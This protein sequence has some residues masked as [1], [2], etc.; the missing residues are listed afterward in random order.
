[1]DSVK[2]KA[3]AEK[4]IWLAPV[5]PPKDEEATVFGKEKQHQPTTKD[6]AFPN[7]ALGRGCPSCLQ[8]TVETLCQAY[9]SIQE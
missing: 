7:Q 9:P 4:R 6:P 5:F 3:P 1:M 2:A 8:E